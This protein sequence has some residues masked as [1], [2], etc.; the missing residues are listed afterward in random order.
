MVLYSIF[1]FFDYA[2]YSMVRFCVR[3]IMLIANYDFFKE[4]VIGEVARKVYIVLGILMLFKMVITA[5]QYM[6]NPDTFDDKDKGMGGLLKKMIIAMAL[7]VLIDPIFEFAKY[8]QESVISTIPGLIL[9]S[10][11]NYKLSNDERTEGIS[12]GKG[13]LDEIGDRVAGTTI[14]AF[15]S[16]KPDRSDAIKKEGKQM[17]LESQN[18]DRL[19]KFRDN[20]T[21]G[22]SGKVIPFEALDVNKCNYDYMFGL[23]TAAG[24]FLLYVM[25]SMTLDIGIRSIKLGIIQILA[26]IPISSYIVSKDKLS[27]FAKMAFNVYIDLFVRLGVIY[28]IIFFIKKVIE[29][30]DNGVTMGDYTASSFEAAFVKIAIIIALFM[31]AKNAPKFICEVLGVNSDSGD[32]KDM[33]KPAWQRAGALGAATGMVKAGAGNAINRAKFTDWSGSPGQKLKNAMKVAGSGI[34]GAASA[35]F[36]GGIAAAQGKN[37][38][39]V[40]AA[41]YKRAIKARQNRDL[42]KLNGVCWTDRAKVRMGDTLGIDTQASLAENKQKAYSTL[43]SDVGSFKKAVMGRI[44][45]TPSIAMRSNGSAVQQLGQMLYDN[46]AIITSGKNEDLKKILRKFDV[47]T[48]A[49]GRKSYTLKNGEHIGYYDLEAVRVNAEQEHI[50]SISG[51]IEPLKTIAQKEIFS[52]AMAGTVTDTSG[53][54][55]D[56]VNFGD[57]GYKNAGYTRGDDGVWRDAAG[58]ERKQAHS[59]I[60]TAVQ[61]A[62]QHITENRVP[63]GEDPGL[64][65]KWFQG[66]VD[67]TDP[68]DAKLLANVSDD[69]RKRIINKD[70]GSLDDEFQRRSEK[71]SGEMSGSSE[72][73]A[74]ASLERR[75]ANKDKK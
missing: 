70:F 41:G 16:E 68:E 40:N 39:E 71:L 64:L 18:N 34:A 1:A 45:K 58:H 30:M 23:S 54:L 20:I 7:L 63:L 43:H 27:K 22:C 65:K 50:G 12:S 29:S 74:R 4:S 10:G 60:T 13:V 44:D 6:I 2:V 37:V 36:H 51:R 26:P 56:E 19:E 73:L 59:D 48:D 5:I 55:L 14:M 75:N 8:M 53:N 67:P 52:D 3:L 47:H 31:F 17:D 62:M 49:S 57:A 42:D 69:L 25:L 15:V 11:E 38:K 46:E 24:L 66:T 33:F 35:G 9:D 21:S 28:F 32:M 72:H 61:S